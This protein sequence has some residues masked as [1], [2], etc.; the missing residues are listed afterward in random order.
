MSLFSAII[1]LGALQGCIQMAALWRLQK[2]NRTANRL[3]AGYI[4]IIVITLAG[5]FF[6]TYRPSGLFYYKILFAGDLIIFL[7]GPLL[8]RYFT[9]L[10]YPARP[11]QKYFALHFLPVILF[12]LS[13]VPILLA[14]GSELKSLLN[15][16][17]SVF[18]FI[19][20]GAILQNI[21]YVV[22]NYS[23]L[24]SFMNSAGSETSY[25]PQTRFYS[26]ILILTSLALAVWMVSFTFRFISS[27]GIGDYLDYHLVWFSL[28][29]VVIALGYYTLKYSEVFNITAPATKPEQAAS[30]PLENIDEL[31]EGLTFVMEK[32]KPYLRPRLTLSELAQLC[33]MTPH[34]LSRVINEKFGKNFFEFVNAYRIEE[35][36]QLA[37]KDEYS[38]LTLLALAF[39]A[40][41]N[42]K[43]TFNTAFRK[44]TGETP[45]SFYSKTVQKATGTFN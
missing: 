25:I 17:G 4:L 33:G 13:I 44:I 2:G 36:K 43:T 12:V 10:F 41:F 20:A 38:H 30:A 6:Y 11:P 14:S 35:F 22:L 16:Y 37:S 24:Q 27:E 31:A 23:L 29:F 18:H 1:L 19:E 7:Y 28:C 15:S 34:L 8:Y 39:E 21:I 32:D 9:A 3:L 42:S 40:G 45:G 26:V 5:R